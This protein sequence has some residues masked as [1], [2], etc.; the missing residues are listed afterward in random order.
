MELFQEFDSL[1]KAPDGKL[2]RLLAY[3]ACAG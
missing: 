1:G 2:V 3:G